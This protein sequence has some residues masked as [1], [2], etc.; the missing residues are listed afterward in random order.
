VTSVAE[1]P[2]GWEALAVLRHEAA[3]GPPHA[4]EGAAVRAVHDFPARR[5]LGLP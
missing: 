4:L 1:G 5:P 2:D 3:G